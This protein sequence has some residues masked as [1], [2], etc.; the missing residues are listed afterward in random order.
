MT[1]FFTKILFFFTMVGANGSVITVAPGTPEST[2]P[3]PSDSKEV[4]SHGGGHG[5]GK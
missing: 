1:Q 2:K 5:V 4:L 3:T